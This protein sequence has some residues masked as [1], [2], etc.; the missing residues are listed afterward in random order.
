MWIFPDEALTAKE[1]RPLVVGVGIERHIFLGFVSDGKVD[2][3]AFLFQPSQ[4]ISHQ[5]R[6]SKS[7]MN[8]EN[9][10]WLSLEQVHGLE[11]GR[12]GVRPALPWT[13]EVT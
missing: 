10:A 1:K 8:Y 7:F 12:A 3:F 11:L 13:Q 5:P 6:P 4:L 2:R 9:M